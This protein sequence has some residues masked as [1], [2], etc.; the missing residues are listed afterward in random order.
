MG[1]AL[2]LLL[3]Y[4]LPTSN[5]YITTA[6]DN[7]ANSPSLVNGCEI[8]WKL[9]KEFVPMFDHTIPAIF[10]SW[11]DLGDLYQFSRLV[12]MYCDLSCN[13]GTPY[14]DAMKSR[15]FLMHGKGQSWWVHTVP[16][17]MELLRALTPFLGT[18]QS[19]NLH[20][21]SPMKP[22]PALRPLHWSHCL[23]PTWPTHLPLSPCHFGAWFSPS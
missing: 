11:P 12:L 1:D 5:N 20:A 21:P 15:M 9:L 2:F 17:G 6:L 4:L 18:S 14:T 7:L 19:W 10:S 22:S 13:Q 8:L 3:E 16:V 23:P